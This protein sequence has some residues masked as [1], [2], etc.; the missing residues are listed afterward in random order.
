MSHL[1]HSSL[2]TFNDTPTSVSLALVSVDADPDRVR[3]EWF[4]SGDRVVFASIYRKAGDG[5]WELQSHVMSAIDGSL[6]F[7]DAKVTSGT[8]YG[9]RLV[10]L[11]AGGIENRI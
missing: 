1:P 4:A 5:E 6:V 7:E 11:D 8:R 2:A 10:V 9:Y 3:L